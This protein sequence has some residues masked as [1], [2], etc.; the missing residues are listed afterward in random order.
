MASGNQ[1]AAE[2]VIDAKVPGGG[3]YQDEELHL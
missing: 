3:R 2:V 1:V